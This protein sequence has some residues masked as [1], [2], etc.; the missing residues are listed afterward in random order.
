MS[1]KMEIEQKYE[2]VRTRSHYKTNVKSLNNSE[3][4]NKFK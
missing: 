1:Q 3:R 4:V 2:G